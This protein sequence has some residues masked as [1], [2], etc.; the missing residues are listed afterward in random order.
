MEGIPVIACGAEQ[1]SV[2]FYSKYAVDRFVYTQPLENK[3]G[4]IRDIL[5]IIKKMNPVLVI[6]S[7]ESTLVALDEC[8]EEIEQYARL[9]APCSEVLAYA[10]D[11]RKTLQ[12]ANC[13]DVPAPSTI[14]GSTLKEIKWHGVAMV[15]FKYDERS[16]SYVL[17]EIN[18][19]FQ[20]STALSLD[21]GLNLPY[22]VACLYGGWELKGSYHYEIGVRERWLRGDLLAMYE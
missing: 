17:M 9:A 19:R 12:L 10:L 7:V 1:R 11:K 22:L 8:R 20:A 13:L 14:R 4:F 15:E 18:G 21:A 2:G 3:S 5:A 6:P 16:D